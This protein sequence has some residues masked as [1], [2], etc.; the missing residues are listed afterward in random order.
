MPRFALAIHGNCPP[1]RRCSFPGRTLTRARFSAQLSGILLGSLAISGCSGRQSALAP[2]SRSA[3][4]LL[5]LTLWMTTGAVV[6]WCVVVGLAV[7]ALHIAPQEHDDRRAKIWIIGGGAVVPTVVLSVLLVYGLSMLPGLVRPAPPGSRQVTVV[8]EQWWWRVRYSEG[9]GEE[10]ELANEIRLP[11]GEPVQFNLESADVIHSFWIPSLG[12]KVDM[13]PGRRTRL[14]LEPTRPGT[15]RGVCAE[16]CGDS[17]ALMAFDVVVTSREEFADWVRLQQQPAGEPQSPLA[18][19][20]RVVFFES[21]CAACH[22]IRGTAANGVV[23]PDLTHVGGRL[24]LAA[25]TL[26]NQREALRSWIAHTST[27]KPGVKMP[28]FHILSDEKLAALA[29]YLE[30]LK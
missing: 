18:E 2:A 8:G 24:S 14:T 15:Y 6:I 16:Y 28:D 5:N 20:G 27:V 29:A 11:V 22:A 13:I 10:F 7:Y 3:E 25:G 12:G 19:R 4:Q 21:G 17:H 23:G 9:N 1:R 30:Q 26:S